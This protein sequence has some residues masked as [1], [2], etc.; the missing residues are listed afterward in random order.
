[1][2]RIILKVILV[3]V[4]AV[5]VLLWFNRDNEASVYF[6]PEFKGFDRI[7]TQKPFFV[8]IGDTQ[9]TSLLEFWRESNKNK[10]PHL[11][12]EIARLNP[13]FV[14]NLGDLVFCATNKSQW[15]RFD[16]AHQPLLNKDIPYFPLPGN[17]EYWC[18]PEK[19][20]ERYFQRFPYLERKKWY[21]FRFNSVGVI[22]LD[23]NFSKLSP[24]EISRQ[25]QWYEKKLTELNKDE[26]IDYIVVCCHNPPFTNSKVVKADGEVKKRFV[27]PFL[28]TA[29]SVVFLSGHC[30]SYEKFKQEGRYFIVSGGGGGPRQK[31]T[32]NKKK[33]PFDDL[34][35]GP[36]KRF[37]HFCQVHIEPEGLTVKVIKLKK[38]LRF[39]LADVFCVPRP[40]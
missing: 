12:A 5:T 2:K 29:K 18:K 3:I 34:Y 39:E 25:Q 28:T 22:L 6:A 23:S 4:L 10:T 14:I 11:I 21:S 40:E 13:A 33:R 17:H 9:G 1:M 15:K 35:N 16:Q 36:A 30:H 37:L 19:S 7:D 8:F 32:I 20:F 27:K 38:N 31:L 24:D 26:E